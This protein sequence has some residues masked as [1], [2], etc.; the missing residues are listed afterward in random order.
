MVLL[1][2]VEQVVLVVEELT[3]EMQVVAEQLIKDLL[4]V[5]E[6]ENHLTMVLEEV[7]LAPWE[8]T[9]VLEEVL[10]LVVMDFL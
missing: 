1:E 2:L 5:L 9:V 4:V 6:T 10:V 7:E 8:Q 3:V